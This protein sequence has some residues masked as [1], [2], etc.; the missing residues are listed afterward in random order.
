MLHAD[1]GTLGERQ[2]QELARFLGWFSIG[3]GAVE[4]LAPRWLARTIGIRDERGLL[5]LFG[6]RE[7]ISGIGILSQR[8]PTGWL[9][10]R[11]AGDAMD[12]AFLAS[13]QMSGRANSTGVALAATAVAGVT[14]LD[15]VAAEQHS[16]HPQARPVAPARRNAIHVYK[17][18]TINRPAQELYEFWRR[19]E[20]LPSFMRHLK[21][22]EMREG[23]K[24]HWVAYAPAGATV[25][26]DAEMID[27]QAGK[28]VAWRS[29]DGAVE[30]SGTVRFQDAPG[31]RGTEVSVEL[32]YRPPGGVPGAVLAQMFGEEPEF[33]ILED[34]RHFKQVMEAGEVCKTEGQPTGRG[35]RS[36]LP[37]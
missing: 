12:L 16:E 26:W 1:G 2:E 19:F 28:C 34:L 9:W 10:G 23:N 5:P 32:D 25:E 15:L 33:Q 31:G 37:F 3:L 36:L 18:I 14:L 27:D 21:S 6:W 13:Q 8:R 30:N 22:V 35:G 11:V 24:S 7:I 17:N 29:I 4:V 20:N